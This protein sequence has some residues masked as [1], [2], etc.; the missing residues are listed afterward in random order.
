[1]KRFLLVFVFLLCAFAYFNSDDADACIAPLELSSESEVSIYSA[2]DLI[3][4]YCRIEIRPAASYFAVTAEIAVKNSG[5][6]RNVTMGVPYYFY[7]GLS[8]TSNVSVNYKG[9]SLKVTRL[10]GI[11]NADAETGNVFYNSYYCWTAEIDNG[12]TAYMYI[13]FT[14]DQRAY[15]NNTKCIDIPLDVL[16]FWSDESGMAEIIIDSAFVNIFSYDRTPSIAPSFVYSDGKLVWKK[17][18]SLYNGNLTVYHNIDNSVIQKFFANVYKSGKEKD[19]SDLFGKRRYAEAVDFIDQNGLSESTDFM[20]MKMVCFEKL[21]LEDDAYEIL[22]AIYDKDVC[23]SADNRYDIS[24]YTR[25]RLLFAYYS[26]VSEKSEELLKQKREILANGIKS[27]TDSKSSVFIT[28]ANNEI[29]TIDSMIK[30]YPQDNGQGD[31]EQKG[32]LTAKQWLGKISEP[33]VIAVGIVIVAVTAFCI[34]GMLS[35]TKR[36]KK[37]KKRTI[38]R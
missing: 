4:Q 30:A 3:M 12:E 21:G 29:K 38:K 9:S 2:D 13:T 37:A 18:I 5:E 27:L 24:E 36:N 14:A 23:F 22:K 25:K 28:W 7:S 8:K 6:K 26:S 16:K 34:A 11:K 20:F 15:E 35:G 19:A 31:V 1:M 10:N 32:D 17:D 33:V